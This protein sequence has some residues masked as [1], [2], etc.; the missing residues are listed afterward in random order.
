A[1][2]QGVEAWMTGVFACNQYIDAQA[3]WTLRKTDPDR[4]RAVLRT[5]IRAIRQLAVAI[6][7]VIPTSASKLLAQLP[8]ADDEDFRVGTPTPIFPRL[9]LKAEEA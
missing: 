5:L 4:M 1:L 9:E 6:L 8:S 3:P 2:S 7:P